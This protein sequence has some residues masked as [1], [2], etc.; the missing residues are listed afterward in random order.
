[1]KVEEGDE[2]EASFPSEKNISICPSL[3]W[4]DLELNSSSPLHSTQC[5]RH[6]LK[7]GTRERGTELKSTKEKGANVFPQPYE[8]NKWRSSS[9]FVTVNNVVNK[10]SYMLA[11]NK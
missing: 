3:N 8:I 6:S 4:T 9:V 10:G 2:G 5:K 7:K 1:M 11:L